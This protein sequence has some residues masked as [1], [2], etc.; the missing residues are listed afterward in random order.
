MDETGLSEL[1]SHD[2]PDIR[3][4]VRV[5]P[6]GEHGT[7]DSRDGILKPITQ[8]AVT[9]HLPD[10]A[11]QIRL[12]QHQDNRLHNLRIRPL[13]RDHLALQLV[14][15]QHQLPDLPRVGRE[16]LPVVRVPVVC[17]GRLGGLHEL[18]EEPLLHGEEEAER[19]ADLAVGAQAGGP[20]VVAGDLELL[21]RL[22]Q[23]LRAPGAGAL[24]L[25]LVDQRVGLFGLW[26][27]GLQRPGYA[28]LFGGGAG[29][30]VPAAGVHGVDVGDEGH[31]PRS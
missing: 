27:V 13:V 28:A 4:Q 9:H 17:D 25:G 23:P 29:V 14:A 19:L 7:H 24:R 5:G 8:V 30:E 11:G 20:D 6:H 1:I 22:Q 18:Q 21:A 26:F 16:G 2:P 31:S 10:V 3:I 15:E 12:T